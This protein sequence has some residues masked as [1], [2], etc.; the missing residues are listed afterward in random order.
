MSAKVFKLVVSCLDQEFQI[1]EEYGGFVCMAPT[2]TEHSKAKWAN[3]KISAKELWE[4]VST[5]SERENI[6]NVL[7]APGLSKEVIKQKMAE[8]AAAL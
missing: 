1:V 3:K 5:P 6:S 8:L 7:K 2:A 4:S